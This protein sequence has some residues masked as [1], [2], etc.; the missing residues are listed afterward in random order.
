MQ[1]TDRVMP[2]ISKDIA[3][4]FDI[5]SWILLLAVISMRFFHG[6]HSNLHIFGFLVTNY[7]EMSLNMDF[8]L[9]KTLELYK[10]DFKYIHTIV[11]SIS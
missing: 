2:E 11:E 5:F 4:F 6:Y 10:V 1:N 3:V 9:I 7:V 8:L